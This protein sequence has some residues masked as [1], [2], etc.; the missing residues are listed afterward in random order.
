MNRLPTPTLNQFTT[1]ALLL[2]LTASLPLA[3]S[4]QTVLLRDDFNGTGNIDT[5]VWRV[6]F[7]GDGASY[8]RTTAK[9]DP[10][11][12]P[13]Q[14][15]GA[16]ELVLDTFFEGT[17]FGGA[18]FI[19]RRQFARGGGLSVTYR[20]KFDANAVADGLVNGLFLYS[21]VVRND[22]GGNPVRDELDWELL[23]NQVSTNNQPFTNLYSEEGFGTAGDGA[24]IASPVVDL[25]Q[26]QDYR[27]DWTPDAVNWYLN[28]TLVRTETANV[29]DDPMALH[30]NLWAPDAGFSDAFSATLQPAASAGANVSYKS[31]I[32]YIEVTRFNTTVG[33][34]LLTNGSFEG[35]EFGVFGVQPNPNPSPDGGWA[36]F[37]NASISSETT[38]SD[39]GFLL[40]TFGPFNGFISDASGAFQDV[41]VTPGQE[42]EASIDAITLSTDTIASTN[43]FT[44]FTLEFRDANDNV[45]GNGRSAAVLDGRDPNVVE[46]EFV[47]ATLNALVPDGAVEARITALFIQAIDSN[48]GP[49]GGSVFW[50]N[51]SINVL[52]VAN[53][54]EG[55]VGDYDDSGSVEQGD[56]NLVLNNWGQDAPFEPNG[57]PFASLA[58]DQEELNRVLNNWGN[59]SNPPSF[60]GFAV[61]E[62]GALAMLSGLA[63]AGLRRRK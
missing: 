32:D 18:E 55:I 29:P 44:E 8:G 45:L 19:S 22:T 53:V 38:A 61:P 39:G 25:T 30:A 11:L 41:A 57:D 51:A 60:E 12:I 3:A 13:E 50:D 26:Y 35:P 40:K 14:V 9:T 16:A 21:G 43:N 5:A 28:D 17:R 34:N 52:E 56:L 7:G 31:Q 6:P 46:D 2:G 47:T 49:D 24:F 23:S 4:A 62:P 15:G 33:D 54:I 27:I 10:A 20:A 63:V 58:V 37:N 42:I 36:A 59:T 1:A 48:G